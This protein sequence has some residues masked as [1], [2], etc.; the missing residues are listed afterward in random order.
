M[1]Y[2][3]GTMPLRRMGLILVSILTLTA[4]LDY[5]Q[6]AQGATE[7][8]S[9]VIT[10]PNLGAATAL[11]AT[12]PVQSAAVSAPPAEHAEQEWLATVRQDLEPVGLSRAMALL[13]LAVVAM[14]LIDLV[15]LTLIACFIAFPTKLA[16][17][18]WKLGAPHW[19]YLLVATYCAAF[20][21][22]VPIFA[23]LIRRS[24][25]IVLVH[26][27]VIGA[28][29]Y[30]WS[31]TVLDTPIWLAIVDGFVLTMMAL[32]RVWNSGIVQ[33]FWDAFREGFREA[34]RDSVIRSIQRNPELL[35]KMIRSEPGILKTEIV[36]EVA[37]KPSILVEVLRLNPQIL[38]DAVKENQQVVS[39]LVT[40]IV[41]KPETL[42]DALRL[43]PQ[44]FKDAVK[45]NPQVVSILEAA[46]VRKLEPL[47]DALRFHP[48]IFKD[49]VKGNPENL[50]TFVR[51][52]LDGWKAASEFKFVLEHDIEKKPTSWA[53][54]ARAGSSVVQASTNL[55]PIKIT[56]PWGR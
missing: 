48:Q 1:R 25:A 13:G 16:L 50:A 15:P 32:P 41:C 18:Y 3:P 7:A 54:D 31:R 10:K 14:G 52:F 20:C 55:Q 35:L 33:A 19:P 22:C 36:A 27:V 26:M 12:A 2:L 11:P 53:A 45:E 5:A 34:N 40:E 24:P 37:Q 47:A 29:T 28:P 8:E 4:S 6:A 9:V 51:L 17:D 46:I 21:Y 44:I 38:K 43:N 39:T 49:A 30:W 23:S 56:N 42:A